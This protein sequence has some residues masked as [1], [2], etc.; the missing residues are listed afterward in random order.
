[1]STLKETI[2]IGKS[3]HLTPDFIGPLISEKVGRASLKVKR[4]DT[5]KEL[6]SPVHDERMKVAPFGSLERFRTEEPVFES[7]A[8]DA[9]DAANESTI[10][11]DR[12]T[13]STD[14]TASVTL[15]EEGVDMKMTPEEVATQ[16]TN[17]QGHDVGTESH[18]EDDDK[19]Q[20]EKLC[21]IERLIKARIVR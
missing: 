19:G 20:T 15:S 10:M 14:Q 21:P 16:T 11:G 5:M 6:P 3:A 9:T 18:N 2:K 17:G 7:D 8:C 4:C 13:R 1:M 12:H